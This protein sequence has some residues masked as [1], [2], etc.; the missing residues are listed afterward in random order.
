MRCLENKILK[1]IL[2]LLVIV[3]SLPILTYIFEGIMGL[4]RIIGTCIRILGT[5]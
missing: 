2:S 4:G 5:I 1:T 3:L